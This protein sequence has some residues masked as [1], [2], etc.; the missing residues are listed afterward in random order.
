[1]TTNDVGA[2]TDRVK[3]ERQELLMKMFTGYEEPENVLDAL[4]ELEALNNAHNDVEKVHHFKIYGR[5]S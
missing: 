1:M 4:E 3:M 5:C 2:R